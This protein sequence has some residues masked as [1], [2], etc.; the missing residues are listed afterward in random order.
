MLLAL[1][2]VLALM[3][4]TVYILKRLLG[5]TAAAG[6]EGEAIKILA[7]R[8]L[9]PKTSILVLDT[10]G[11]VVVVGIAANNM[12]LITT[13]EDTERLDAFRRVE[14]RPPLPPSALWEKVRHKMGRV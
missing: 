3:V 8:S 13:I 6:G 4:G 7:A 2:V 10:L 1:G 11:K 14:E 5:R 9:G 12:H